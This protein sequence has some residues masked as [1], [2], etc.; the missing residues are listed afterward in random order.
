MQRREESVRPYR[1]RRTSRNRPAGPACACTQYRQRKGGRFGLTPAITTSYF[2][3][4]PFG[5]NLGLRRG[6]GGANEGSTRKS[7]DE[8]EYSVKTGILLEGEMKL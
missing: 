2:S 4:E 7:R 1:A 3:S 6:T 5:S 8:V